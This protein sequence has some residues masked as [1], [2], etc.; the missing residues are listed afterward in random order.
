MLKQFQL[1][2]SFI[3]VSRLCNQQWCMCGM[4][5]RCA[6]GWRSAEQTAVAALQ[7]AYTEPPSFNSTN[8]KFVECL[9]PGESE[10]FGM[11]TKTGFRQLMAKCLP[12]LPSNSS[13]QVNATSQAPVPASGAAQQPAVAPPAPQSP[14]NGSTSSGALTDLPQPPPIPALRTGENAA[15]VDANESSDDGLS[16]SVIILVAGGVGVILFNFLCDVESQ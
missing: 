12:T 11:H 4:H 16:K 2:E 14:M 1:L 7:A 5:C 3:Y 15:P 10:L 8:P 13:Q 6:D 9:P